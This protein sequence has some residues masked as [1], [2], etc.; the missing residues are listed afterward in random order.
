[1]SK[2]LGDYGCHSEHVPD[3]DVPTTRSASLGRLATEQLYITVE[4]VHFN[5]AGFG[6]GSDLENESPQ[7]GIAL[8]SPSPSL[9][10]RRSHDPKGPY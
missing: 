3:P 4:S 8:P 7:V 10:G 6:R 1:M 2:S 5:R 9:Y